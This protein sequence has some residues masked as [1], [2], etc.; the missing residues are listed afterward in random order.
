MYSNA[1]VGISISEEDSLNAGQIAAQNA[2]NSSNIKTPL[3]ALLFSTSKHDPYK[4]VEGVTQVLGTECKIFGGYCFGI[5]TH[6]VLSTAGFEVGI[7]VIES[8]NIRLNYFQAS[9][10][11]SNEFE[12]GK[13]LGQQIKGAGLLSDSSILLFYDSLHHTI[14]GNPRLNMASPMLRGISE[15]IESWPAIAGMGVMGD[16]QFLPSYQWFESKVFRKRSI[17]PV[18]SLNT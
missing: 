17:N 13:I 15:F 11:P 7:I 6:T 18:L 2:L 12:V 3:F 14:D 4:L 5:F 10:L 16:A 9:P 1:G 8:D